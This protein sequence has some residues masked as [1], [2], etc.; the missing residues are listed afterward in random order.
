MGYTVIAPIG[1][2]PEALFLGMKEF[3]T[4]RVYLITAKTNLQK[5][6]KIEKK[7]KRKIQLFIF[8]SIR[9]INNEELTN[10]IINGYLLMGRV[11][12]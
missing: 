2:N 5:A 12:I 4:E 6:K 8:K 3:A 9:D 11:K 7:L 10:S 1:D